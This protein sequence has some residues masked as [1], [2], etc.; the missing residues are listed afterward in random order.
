MLQK[1]SQTYFIYS[2]KEIGAE[3]LNKAEYLISFNLDARYDMSLKPQKI[4]HLEEN[5]QKNL[6]F[7]KTFKTGERFYDLYKINRPRSTEKDI[8][9]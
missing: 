5:L 6:T 2:H 9:Q 7:I 4:A 3:E 1:T 8:V